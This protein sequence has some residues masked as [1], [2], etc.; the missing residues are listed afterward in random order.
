M[1]IPETSEQLNASGP[2]ASPA[3]IYRQDSKRRVSFQMV[4]DKEAVN[5]PSRLSSPDELMAFQAANFPEKGWHI[6]GVA[7]IAGQVKREQIV[8]RAQKLVAFKQ[9]SS[10]LE[11]RPGW[12]G[13]QLYY[14]VPMDIYVGSL[15][16]EVTLTANNEIERETVVTHFLEGVVSRPFDS[17]LPQWEIILL[18]LQPSF[19]V[20]E[21]E[22]SSVLILRMAHYLGDGYTAIC[23]LQHL[24]DEKCIEDS[25]WNPNS[26]NKKPK[27]MTLETPTSVRLT[28][29]ASKENVGI[30][31][32]DSITYLFATLAGRLMRGLKSL[33]QHAVDIPNGAYIALIKP[34]IPDSI[35]CFAPYGAPAGNHKI[36]FA[37]SIEVE[38]V[39]SIGR[40]IGGGATI[41]DVFFAVL[42]GAI[43]NY[44]AKHDRMLLSN[45]LSRLT[46]CV[47][48]SIRTCTTWGSLRPECFGA[49]IALV[50]LPIPFK[51]ESFKERVRNVTAMTARVKRW[52]LSWYLSLQGLLAAYLP[53]PYW[54][55][56]IGFRLIC[57]ENFGILRRSCGFT[58]V[59]GPTKAIK[60]C[61]KEV[62]R[63]H[64]LVNMGGVFT[65]FSYN[66]KIY[67]T[68]I[69]EDT[70]TDCE[71]FLDK[72]DREIR[73]LEDYNIDSET[74][75]KKVE[76]PKLNEE[77]ILAN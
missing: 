16:E 65:L 46:C 62:T 74:A 4:Q 18:Q 27:M 37:K 33:L 44:A 66:G 22:I 75:T 54:F 47:L 32:T 26:R 31:N 73:G 55:R 45:R 56:H 12:F 61:D 23:V 19:E 10:R 76:T 38:R 9:F 20:P 72:L 36:R 51:L 64:A 43:R 30:P 5:E 57:G 24:S 70:V 35:S 2:W 28:Q 15:I 67:P 49:R 69:T 77:N 58:N 68:I 53:R 14:S 3:N 29:D 48:K 8:A 7:W 40:D 11:I 63:I 60:I 13:A 39:K 21:N 50:Y 52:P 59:P 41:N 6:H 25:P 71:E 17:T 42:A 34:A 1:P